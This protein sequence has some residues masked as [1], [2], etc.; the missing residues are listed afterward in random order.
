[1][2][3]GISG[4]GLTLPTAGSRVEGYKILP[5]ILLLDTSGSTWLYMAT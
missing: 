3:R 1:M 2:A 4:I 5:E